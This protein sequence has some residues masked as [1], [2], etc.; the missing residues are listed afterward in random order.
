MACLCGE[1][2]DISP[3]AVGVNGCFIFA[4]LIEFL[5]NGET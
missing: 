3:L 2:C 1:R 5:T 4:L